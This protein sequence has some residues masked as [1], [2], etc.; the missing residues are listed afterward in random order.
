MTPA[1]ATLLT[2]L[3]AA[4]GDAHVL[5]Q[6]GDVAPYLTDQRDRFHGQAIA[7]VRPRTADEVAA[8]VRACA[9]HATPIV[10]QGGNTGMC[11]G[12]TPDASGSA[13]LLSLV[14]LD[15]VRDVDAPNATVTVEAGVP[16]ARV[17]EAAAAHGL[18]FPLSLASEG[19]C[20]IGGNLSTN[21]G[22]TAVLRFGNARELCLGVEVVLADGRIFSGLRGLRKDNTGYDLKQLFIGAEG[23]LGIVTAAVLKLFPAPRTRVTALAGLP[24]VPAAIGLLRHGRAALGDRLVG[25]EV[26][27]AA[28]VA[29]SQRHHP[30]SPDPLPGHAWYVLLQADD[31]AA[32]AP[33]SRLMEAALA[34]AAEQGIVADATIA[35][36]QDQARR[37]WSLRENASEAQRREG[38]NV[39]HDIS[40][41][42]SAIPAFLA[43]AE[44][45]LAE[46][47]AG[48]R[49]YVFG[50]LG[51][52]N[53]HY[54]LA[55]PAGADAR[56]FMARAPEVNRI[57]HDLVDAA[58]GSISAEHG[59]GQLK[60]DEL[61][62]YKAQVEIELMQ[63][64]KCALDPGNLLNPGKVVPGPL[65]CATAA[66]GD[67]QDAGP[68]SG[69]MRAAA[70]DPR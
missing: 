7:V 39:K 30:G 2:A 3:R 17:Q 40:L 57:V 53:L 61:A 50:H 22:G 27:S 36:S 58:G 12:A 47:F 70:G 21:A 46:A 64:I 41:P 52:G 37:L 19:S 5:H 31:S 29:V 45:A 42:V 18:L 33:L 44:R 60:R 23:T 15:R 63:R 55:A 25:F 54:N 10:P 1:Q 26:M 35:Q 56:A 67:A 16:L 20:T 13:V 43:E 4:V 34:D 32:D 11:G 14:R 59:I 24:D 51:D 62:R 49:L 48:A 66:A 65:P 6:H 38:P 68:G 69:A 9:A 28:T 8:V